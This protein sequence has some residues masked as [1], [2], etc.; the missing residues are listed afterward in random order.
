MSKTEKLED[1]EL[2]QLAFKI[3]SEAYTKIGEFPDDEKWLAASRLRQHA[4]GLTDEIA[5]GVGSL[6][7]RDI[8]YYLGHAR[9]ELF[10][11]KA[12]YKAG[13]SSKQ[14]DIDPDQMVLIDSLTAKIDERLAS[15]P[16][17]LKTYFASL[18]APEKK[19]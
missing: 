1:S 10:A 2:W 9:K 19:K 14:V 12:V 16:E 3:A 7:P 13:H 5:M 15:I 4:G 18:D 8:Q 11:I 17:E 6:D